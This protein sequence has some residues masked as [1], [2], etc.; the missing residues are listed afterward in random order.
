MF[1]KLAKRMLAHYDR[2]QEFYRKHLP[3]LLSLQNLIIRKIKEHQKL[4]ARLSFLFAL[5]GVI[6][7]TLSSIHYEKPW[8]AFGVL[9]LLMLMSLLNTTLRRR[10]V[11]GDDR[12]ATCASWMRFF[13]FA[14]LLIFIGA[15][16]SNREYTDRLVR[17]AA[18]ASEEAE[19]LRKER[20]EKATLLKEEITE[21]NRRLQALSFKV[22]YSQLSAP[23]IMFECNGSTA[24]LAGT[25]LQNYNALLAQAEAECGGDFDLIAGEK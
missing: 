5:L 14:L 12:V 9:G 21:N 17:E 11:S 20:E 1:T 8:G 19:L 3:W 2:Q 10:F 16:P 6:V 25:G 22:K 4:L 13:S 15:I 23:K 18:D 7:I 24:Y